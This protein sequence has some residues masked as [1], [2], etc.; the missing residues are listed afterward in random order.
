LQQ[1]LVA[2]RSGETQR[3][4]RGAGFGIN[5]ETGPVGQIIALEKIPRDK[6]IASRKDMCMVCL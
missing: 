1:F 5:D 3:A 4:K 6:A 2:R